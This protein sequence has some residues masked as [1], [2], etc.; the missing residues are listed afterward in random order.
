MAIDQ[1]GAP[2]D[3]TLEASSHADATAKLRAQ[4]MTILALDSEQPASRPL[5]HHPNLLKPS[6][7]IHFFQQLHILLQSGLAITNSL[8]VVAQNS[9]EALSEVSHDVLTNIERGTSLFHAVEATEKF[10]PVIVTLLKV[11]ERTGR[12]AAVCGRLT[13]RLQS[14]ESRRRDLISA[15]AYPCSIGLVCAILIFLLL[16]SMLPSFTSTFAELGGELP[17]PTRI[18]LEIGEGPLLPVLAASLLL[19][20]LGLYATRGTPGSLLL[21]EK[22]IYETP[23]VGPIARKALLSRISTDL[24]MMVDLG[25]TLDRALLYL[26]DP[27][28]G[29]YAMDEALKYA[30]VELRAS[31]DLDTAFP[32]SDLFPGVWVQM[33]HVGFE[34]GR[35][36]RMLE[37]YAKMADFE[38]EN[39]VQRVTQLLEPF[40]MISMGL[41]VGGIVL[42]AFLPMYSL[43]GKF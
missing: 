25:I 43:V 23:L 37:S 17:L 6:D 32:R 31:G 36:S 42:A 28:S 35:L 19:F 8:D 22:L 10:G 26:A 3:G 5:V 11:A 18:L 34:T 38:V 2:Q 30:R 33:T 13:E 40:M 16:T 21:Q 14:A 41:I 29:Y 12:L 1:S 20:G 15:L 4:G 24:A 7:R 39:D 9:S 27:T